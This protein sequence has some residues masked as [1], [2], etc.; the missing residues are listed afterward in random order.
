MPFLIKAGIDLYGQWYQGEPMPTPRSGHACVALNGL[1]YCIGGFNGVDWLNVVEAYDPT[2]NTWVT[3]S[4]MPTARDSMAAAVLAGKIHVI[5]GFGP[6]GALTVHEIYDPA[7][8]TWTTA[9]ALPAPPKFYLAAASLFGRVFALGGYDGSTI[10]NSVFSRHRQSTAWSVEAS[11]PNP[12]YAAATV[13]LNG[14]IYVLAGRSLTET[15]LNQ[16]YDPITRQWQTEIPVPQGKP[17]MKAVVVGGMIHALGGEGF[18]QTHQQYNP[19]RRTWKE[20]APLPLG[21]DQFGAAA[22]GDRIFVIGG[23]REGQYLNRVDIW[24]P[25]AEE[26]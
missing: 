7:T 19:T 2:S 17:D 14:R 8:D 5:G 13:A 20:R 26:R 18:A 15:N 1:V 22:V 21:R 25:F 10:Q 9:T 16:S 12:V 11:M 23:Y 4:P 6:N 24:T 3:K